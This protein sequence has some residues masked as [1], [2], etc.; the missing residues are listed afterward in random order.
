MTPPHAIDAHT[1]FV[2]AVH[3]TV[4]AALQARSRRMLW[5][6]PDFSGWPLDDAALLEEL[7]SW[8]RQP[9]RELVLLATQFDE[10]RRSQARFVGWYRL[11]S[12]VVQA[13]CPAPED[14]G[15]LPS[16]LL[17]DGV[18]VVQL[19]DK[20]HW[21]GRSSDDRAEMRLW[22][23]QL[24]ACIQRSSPALPASTIGL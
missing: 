18:A 2:A 23:D 4:A 20:M 15:E 24:D 22:R 10:L 19:T 17:A 6:D 16:L 3:R 14:A 5:V 7:A 9:Q 11:W 8:L 13:R 12:H 1:D 21:R